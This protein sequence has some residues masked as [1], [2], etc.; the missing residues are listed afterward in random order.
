MKWSTKILTTALLAAAVLTGCG[1]GTSQP[2]S[3]SQSA[4]SSQASNPDVKKVLVGTMGTYSPFT[5]QD[6]SGKLTGY[7][8]EVL[9]EVDKRVKEIELEFVPT[10]WDSMFLGLESNKYQIVANQ[11][12]KNPE[13]EQKYQFTDNSYFTSQSVIVV[14]KGRQGISTLDSLN[15]LT[16]GSAVGDSFTKTL[17]DYNK[18]HNN[19]INIKYYDGNTTTVLQDV[20]AGRIDAYLNDPIMVTDAIKK[21]GLK[22]EIVGEPVE[23]VPTY[24]VFR[25]DKE[26]DELK[27][28]IDKALADIIQDGT[29][30]KLSIQWFDKDYTKTKGK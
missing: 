23:S 24:F 3:S 26:G 21:L 9:R 11:I 4:S 18:T 25:K 28:Q 27:A 10:P 5:Y 8:I 7:D 22:V 20:E 19:A 13:R 1:T 17:E 14:K 12:V 6:D 16:V 30:S 2:T 29:L 15:G